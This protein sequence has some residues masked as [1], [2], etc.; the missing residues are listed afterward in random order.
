MSGCTRYTPIK[1][2]TWHK[3]GSDRAQTSVLCNLT[4]SCLCHCFLSIFHSSWLPA[5]FKRA[6]I[7]HAQS[8]SGM[9]NVCHW[10]SDFRAPWAL[11]QKRSTSPDLFTLTP[12]TLRITCLLT[13]LRM[14]YLLI[15]HLL[16]LQYH[17][18]N[19]W[20]SQLCKRF[21]V[22]H[23]GWQHEPGRVGPKN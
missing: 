20:S 8:S 11:G 1:L 17:I 2:F 7:R 15:I 4:C 9:R 18:Q 14:P 22:Y 23:S 13:R 19:P 16:S 3:E 12:Y 5:A 21:D 10:P 6:F